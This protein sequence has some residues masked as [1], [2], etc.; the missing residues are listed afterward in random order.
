MLPDTFRCYVVDKNPDGNVVAQFAERS[1][2][3]LS[4]GEAVVRVAYSSLNY[5]DALAATGHP[6]VAR[7]FPL[8]PGVDVVGKVVESGVYEWV[9]GDR[10]LATGF[11]LGVTHWGGF[12]EY[13]RL[14][15]GWSLPLPEGLSMRESMIFGTAGL[16]AALCIEALQHHD[17]A[18][19]SGDVV[20]TGASGGVGSMAVAILA[21]LGYRV[22]AV[23]GKPSAH[24]LL[25]K[26]GAA[27]IVG[28]E[29]VDDHSDKPLL[30]R[31]FAGAVDTVGGNTL[32]TLLRSVRLRGCVA[33]CGMVGGVDLPMTVYPFILRGVTLA[34][35]DAAECP[36]AVR[37][38]VW[39]KLAGP[40]KPE[41]LED[42]AEV[43]EL[44]Q[45]PEKIDAILGGRITGRVVVRVAGDE[46]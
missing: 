11:N 34:G 15:L 16:T 26:L 27:E 6:G 10:L 2:D 24:P 18:P 31:R 22:I 25:E 29:A 7:K 1:A 40:W 9:E 39:K 43:V 30:P 45:L 5:K 32:G 23:S 4:P 12:A 38:R 20:V 33:A 19:D 3:D 46:P 37:D 14:P 21:K 35:I 17:I 8:V 36:L 28:R 42:L 13:A 41:H 44:D